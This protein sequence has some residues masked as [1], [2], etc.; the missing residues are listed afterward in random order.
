M[1][2]DTQTVPGDDHPSDEEIEDAIR[3]GISHSPAAQLAA[4]NA[5]NLNATLIQGVKSFLSKWAADGA[6]SDAVDEHVVT[7]CANS[8]HVMNDDTATEDQQVRESLRAHAVVA[9]YALHKLDRS[10]PVS[11]WGELA[12]LVGIAALATSRVR[13]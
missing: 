4:L 9:A 2:D 13:D 7:V 3:L 5:E 11:V 12:A 10:A 8:F 1:S 6:D